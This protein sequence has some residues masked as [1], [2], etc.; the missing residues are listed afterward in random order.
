M[1]P[2]PEWAPDRAGGAVRGGVVRS[3]FE[4]SKTLLDGI[5]AAV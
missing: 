5:G 1:M 2:I 3:E 4:W